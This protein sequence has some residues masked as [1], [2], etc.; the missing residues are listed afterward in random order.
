MMGT[1]DR[2]TAGPRD[3]PGMEMGLGNQ[4]MKNVEYTMKWKRIFDGDNLRR[5]R[6]KNVVT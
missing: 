1:E 3:G 4:N 5:I 6:E 2:Q